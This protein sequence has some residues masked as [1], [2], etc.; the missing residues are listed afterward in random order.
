MCNVQ[1]IV[2][3]ISN[4]TDVD[5][6]WNE[7]TNHM[8]AATTTFQIN[9]CCNVSN[10]WKKKSMHV[11]Y[12]S[13]LNTGK[14]VRSMRSTP[15][16][17]FCFASIESSEQSFTLFFT[18]HLH[19]IIS[20]NCVSF[21]AIFHLTYLFAIIRWFPPMTPYFHGRGY[22]LVEIF[23]RLDSSCVQLLRPITSAHF[24]YRR[25]KCIFSH[26]S[27]TECMT[28]IYILHVR[29]SAARVPLVLW[30][31]TI[32]LNSACCISNW[33]IFDFGFIC[34]IQNWRHSL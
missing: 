24:D 15:F 33:K 23:S 13:A 9:G 10:E 21:S 4:R 30:H 14:T 32:D 26:I 16:H 31:Q 8:G 6:G 25:F 11:T 12:H 18:S 7:T 17:Q 20:F 3:G 29:L 28:V 27:L 5:D 22:W 34:L 19:F 2:C 1:Y